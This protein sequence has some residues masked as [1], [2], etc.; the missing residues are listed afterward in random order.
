MH[1]VAYPSPLIL[2][3]NT[4]MRMNSDGKL[5]AS[6]RCSP[7]KPDVGVPFS[8]T[9]P[10]RISIVQVVRR[11]PCETRAVDV[12]PVE[13]VD[14]R[15]DD[16]SE[17]EVGPIRRPR[18]IGDYSVAER[19]DGRQAGTVRLHGKETIDGADGGECDPIAA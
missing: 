5:V 16:A 14:D 11:Q 10:R 6:R 12:D 19:R 1:R 7:F 9:R 8:L 13:L 15:R 3:S 18:G 17:H 2:L 4:K